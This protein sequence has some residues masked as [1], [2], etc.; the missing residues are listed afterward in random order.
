VETPT[1]EGLE[2]S[3]FVVLM[4]PAFG[5]LLKNHQDRQTSNIRGTQVD[6]GWSLG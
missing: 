3:A 4:L 2:Y 6:R 5:N 1:E